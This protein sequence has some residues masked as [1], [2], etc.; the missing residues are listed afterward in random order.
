MLNDAEHDFPDFDNP[1]VVETVLSVQFEKLPAMRSVY[2]GL[3]WQRV[4]DRFPDTQDR[5]ALDPVIEQDNE[6]LS[7]PVQLRFEVRETSSPQ[8]L[9]LLNKTGTEMMQIQNDRFIK[10]WRKTDEEQEYPRYEPV[11]RPA[12]ERDFRGFQAF[13]TDEGLGEARVNQCEVTYVN[14][15]VAGEGWS[16]WDEI[17]KIFTFLKQPPALPY[18]GRA[19]D[20]GFRTRFPIYGPNKKWIGR[21]H[22]DVQPSLRYSDNKPMYALNLTAR[23]MCGTGFDFFDI[24]R[25]WVV[26]SFEQLT[27]PHMHKVWRKK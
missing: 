18:P 20:F 12:F 21:L 27:T 23:G 19:E 6:T 16:R 3:F 24:G 11:I 10:N 8:R 14:H 13:L 4:R 17:E 9:W 7:Q 1:P 22:V 25:R 2:F 26:K 5:P 15:M